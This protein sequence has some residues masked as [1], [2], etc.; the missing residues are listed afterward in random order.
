MNTQKIGILGTG[1]VGQSL[2]KGLLAKGYEV[3]VGSRDGSKAAAL[4]EAMGLDIKTGT[5]REVAVWAEIIILAVKGSAAEG[6]AGELADV[7]AGKVVIDVTNPIADTA[8]EQ[9]VLHYFTSL[10]RSLGEMVQEAAPEALVVKAWNS[11][12][13]RHMVDPAFSIPPTMP[14]CGNDA[15]ARAVV[16]ALLTDCGWESE[17]MGSIVSARA[18]EPLCMLWCIPGLQKNDWNHV[19]KLV[20][21]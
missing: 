18:I 7:F 16:T 15:A 6:V 4:D 5:F 20:R 10:E 3:V 19:F 9:G 1:D 2:T 11:V 8:P 13:H 14:L 17:D 12:G 21:A